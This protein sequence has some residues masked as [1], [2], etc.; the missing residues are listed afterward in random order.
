MSSR[1]CRH[2][3]EWARNNA[4][5]NLRLY[6]A[7]AGLSEEELRAERTSFFKTIFATLS[8]NL[9]VDW[10]Y[11]DA[12]EGGGRGL[13]C[14]KREEPY[15]TFPE[16]RAASG[17]CD[18]RLV[19]FCEKLSE[20]QLDAEIRLA[21]PNGVRIER[22]ESV[23]AHLFEHQI[24]HRGQVHAMLSGTPIPPPQLDEYF[25]EQDAPLRA[26]ELKALG[27]PLR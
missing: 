18:A 23:L 12:L 24:H 10:Y 16:L 2:L 25:L 5:A 27:F 6:S 4:W 13:D 15:E 3:L 19:A 17:A 26:G 1:L 8:H 22:V 7:S 14:F 20:E 11:I 9:I 21:R